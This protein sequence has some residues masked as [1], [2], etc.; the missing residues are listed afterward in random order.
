[1]SETPILVGDVVGQIELVHTLSAA[2]GPSYATLLPDYKHPTSAD[3]GVSRSL[4]EER[5]LVVLEVGCLAE[6][7]VSPQV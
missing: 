7:L 3:L 1:M 4:I 6:V 5:G 2:A